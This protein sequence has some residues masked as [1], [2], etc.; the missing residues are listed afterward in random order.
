ILGDGHFATVRRCIERSTGKEFAIKSIKIANQNAADIKR[1]VSLLRTLDHPSIMK[2]VD[3]FEDDEFVHI[4][5]EQYTGGELFDKI[6]ENTTDDHCLPESEA[7]RIIHS[8]LSAVEYLHKCNIVHRD[9]KPEN[10]L[11][12]TKQRD[13]QIKLI[14][15]GLSQIHKVGDPLMTEAVGTPYYMCPEQLTR[16]YDRSCDLWAIGVVTFILLAGHP[17][18][19]GDDSEIFRAIRSG[20]YVY[21]PE[22]WRGISDGAKHFVDSLLNRDP[23]E[24]PTATEAL[25]HLWFHQFQR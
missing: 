13:S 18:F 9:I 17:P 7:A 15:F 20:H 11:F 14:D 3:V 4:I 6:I 25:E 2:L 1:E 23:K 16:N 5:S 12:A 19:A 22:R 24:R 10:V 21:Y 8:I